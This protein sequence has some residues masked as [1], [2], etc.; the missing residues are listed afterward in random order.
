MPKNQGSTASRPWRTACSG[1]N[2]TIELQPRVSSTIT[3]AGPSA[4]RLQNRNRA[5]AA[6]GPEGPGGVMRKVSAA[7]VTASAVTST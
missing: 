7:M 3:P 1:T 5:E 6:G 4:C 2:P